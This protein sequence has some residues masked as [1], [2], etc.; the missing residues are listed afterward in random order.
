MHT[1]SAKALKAYREG[2]TLYDFVD[3]QNAEKYFKQA[4]ETDKGF[5]EAYMMLGE[6]LFRQARYGEAAE[7][8]RNAV[9]IDSL[10]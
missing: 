8:Y 9:N 2:K 1:N 7:N 4:V 5:Y 6:L 10:H 3:Y